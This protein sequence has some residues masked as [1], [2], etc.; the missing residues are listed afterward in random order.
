MR[1]KT[2]KSLHDN[3]IPLSQI[4]CKIFKNIYRDNNNCPEIFK[5]KTQVKQFYEAKTVWIPKPIKEIPK[6][7]Y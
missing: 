5:V 1:Q 2:E 3:S 6:K 7:V 4:H